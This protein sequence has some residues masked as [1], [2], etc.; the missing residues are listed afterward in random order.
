[1][2][3]PLT[4]IDCG[5]E[6]VVGPRCHSC[7]AEVRYKVTEIDDRMLALANEG[8]SLSYIAEEFGITKQRAQQRVARARGRGTQ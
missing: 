6:V 7:A 4:C 5:T 8:R 1:M 3:E 2:P